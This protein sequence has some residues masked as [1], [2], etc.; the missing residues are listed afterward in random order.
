MNIMLYTQ[1][2][3]Y[4]EKKEKKLFHDWEKIRYLFIVFKFY[5]SDFTT[6]N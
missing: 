3:A 1:V 6:W 2:C 5:V 4:L